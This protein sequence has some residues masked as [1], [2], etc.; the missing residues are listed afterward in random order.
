MA[1]RLWY[2]RSIVPDKGQVRYGILIF[3]W[4]Y[5]WVTNI[6]SDCGLQAGANFD[7]GTH[8]S[9]IDSLWVMRITNTPCTSTHTFFIVIGYQ[10]VPW[11]LSANLVPAPAQAGSTIWRFKTRSTP[12]KTI[13]LSE[14]GTLN[15]MALLSR[16]RKLLCTSSNVG[17]NWYNTREHLPPSDSQWEWPILAALA[18]RA[19]REDDQTNNDGVLVLE[20]RSAS[21]P[22]SKNW[23]WGN[24]HRW[25]ENA[26]FVK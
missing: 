10:W 7:P 11:A 23:H 20:K 6:M 8:D 22:I 14:C 12:N 26:L 24:I 21:V 19:R 16:G 1:Y 15:R 13:K 3:S 5:I 25:V 4:S 2:D 9:V 17:V 18:L